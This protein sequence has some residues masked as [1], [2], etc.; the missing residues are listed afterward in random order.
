M[1][2]GSGHRSFSFGAAAASE[3]ASGLSAAPDAMALME[4]FGDQAYFEARRRARQVRKGELFNADR[5]TEHWY[6]VPRESGRRMGYI[7]RTGDRH[8]HRS[9]E[10]W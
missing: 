6:R 3:L 1:V 9:R 10:L 8:C 2:V 4:Q 5:P 7:P